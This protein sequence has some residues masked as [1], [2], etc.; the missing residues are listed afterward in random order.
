MSGVLGGVGGTLTMLSYGYWIRRRRGAEGLKIS[1]LDLAVSY[2]VT[3]F[4]SVVIIIG[5][6]LDLTN[7]AKSNF[8]L[9]V[10]TQLRDILGPF[11]YYVLLGFGGVSLVC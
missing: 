6:K 8:S 5:S 4:F 2:G 11:G 7:V 9:T 1:R 10:A 3:S